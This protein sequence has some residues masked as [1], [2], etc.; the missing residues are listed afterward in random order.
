MQIDKSDA[1]KYFE[2][3]DSKPSSSSNVNSNTP[4]LV[5]EKGFPVKLGKTGNLPADQFQS[6]DSSQPEKRSIIQ[7]ALDFTN[8]HSGVVA[9]AEMGFGVFAMTAAT[10]LPLLPVAIPAVV[11]TLGFIA[12]AC[13]LGD[14]IRRMITN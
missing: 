14:G 4:G 2:K 8:E 3:I 7:R 10:I 9:P 13:L 12:G 1:L 5:D 11:G 6:L